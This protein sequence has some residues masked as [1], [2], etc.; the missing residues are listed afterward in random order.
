[1]DNFV[2]QEERDGI[3][4]SWNVWPTS[5]LEATR[6]VVPLGCLYSP[7]KKIKDLP[8]LEYEPVGC[9]SCHAILNRHW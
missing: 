1:M 8:V 6:M 2:A 7:M 9:K 5:G 3:R 4:W